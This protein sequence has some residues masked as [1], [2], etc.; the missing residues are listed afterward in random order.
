MPDESASVVVIGAGQ[1]GLSVAYYLQRLG[2]RA[3][4]DFLVLDRGPLAGGAWQNRWESLRL[5]SAHRV[6]DLPNMKA[7]DLSFDSADR[8]RPARDVVVEYYARYEE[9]FDLR[10]RRPSQVTA[11][12]DRGAD[13]VLR[14]T[15]GD[16]VAQAVVNA[17]GTWGAP[18]VPYY[19]GLQQFRG[20]Q[21][22]TATYSAAEDFRGQRVLVV[23]GGTSAIGFL[24]ELEGVAQKTFWATRRPVDYM[25]HGTLSLED[26]VTAVAAQ[27][28][29]ARSGRAL[30]SIVSGTGVP[31]TRRIAAGIA[32]GVLDARPMFSRLEEDAVVW[33]DGSREPIDAIVW[34]TGFRPDVRHLSP[35]H[36]HEK[37][38]GIVVATGAAERDPR[39]FFAGYGPTASTVGANRAGRVVARQV[40]AAIGNRLPQ[41]APEPL[42]EPALQPGPQSAPRQGRQ[43]PAESGLPPQP[44]RARGSFRPAT[45]EVPVSNRRE[46]EKDAVSILARFFADD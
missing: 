33:P 1:A 34:A 27:D 24:L 45:G 25:D 5:G 15:T 7:L 22:H 42:P 41:P 43:A 37:E 20:Q 40:F 16:I 21:V 14:S 4:S 17:T 46:E 9:F 38:G 8:S 31:K 35:L 2:M 39:I 29:A 44:A 10:V 36:L 11:V 12:F 30:P 13:L 6:H 3:G 28:A 32:R 26:A 18:F 23:G 19:P